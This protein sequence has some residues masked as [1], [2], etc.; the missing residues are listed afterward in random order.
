MNKLTL[1]KDWNKHKS[2]SSVTVDSARAAWLKSH[3]YLETPTVVSKTE[4]R[5]AK[6]RERV[7]KSKTD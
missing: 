3:G 4:T 2:G 1:G 6:P 5:K 7:S